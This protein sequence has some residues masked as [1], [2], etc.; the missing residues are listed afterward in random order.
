MYV[1]CIIGIASKPTHDIDILYRI[2]LN[3]KYEFESVAQC[4]SSKHLKVQSLLS[5]L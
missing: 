2:K 5:P 3:T 1:H 4:L